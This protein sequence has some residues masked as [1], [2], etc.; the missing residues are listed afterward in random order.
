MKLKIKEETGKPVSQ[1]LLENRILQ[2]RKG[3]KDPVDGTVYLVPA[4]YG[5]IISARPGYNSKGEN[6]I[7]V[8]V[9]DALKNP[10][11]NKITS[12]PYRNTE[13]NLI[14]ADILN[15]FAKVT[16]GKLNLTA[17]SKLYPFVQFPDYGLADALKTLFDPL[18]FWVRADESGRIATGPRLGSPLSSA[19]GILGYPDQDTAPPAGS[20][21][22]VFPDSPGVE[23]ID[24]QWQ[25]FDGVYNQVRVLGQSVTAQQ[26]LGPN[27]LLFVEQDSSV[28]AKDINH[29][30]WPF[31]DQG[32]ASSANAVVAKNCFV[33]F[34]YST[35]HHLDDS[36]HTAYLSLM[37]WRG[38][39]D[40]D[41]TYAINEA[42]SYGGSSFACSQPSDGTHPPVDPLYWSEIPITGPFVSSVT[43]KNEDPRTVGVVTL[44][45]VTASYLIL[46]IEGKQYSV[47]NPYPR[48]YG[49]FDYNFKIWGQPVLS[50]SRTLTAYADYDP[51][52]VIGEA[53]DD[54]FDDN[55]T[56]Q[57]AHSPFGMGTP[58]EVFQDGVSLGKIAAD[59]SELSGEANYGVDFE[60]GRVVLNDTSYRTFA[61][62]QDGAG[63][64]VFSTGGTAHTTSRVFDL[65]QITVKTAQEV[66][67]TYRE[68]ASTFTLPGLQVGQ[69]YD[70]R[71]HFADPDNTLVKKRLF[72]VYAQ[73]AKVIEGLDIVAKTGAAYVAYQ[74]TI[75]GI[76]PD[77]SG[78]IVIK[79]TQRDPVSNDLLP[80]CSADGNGGGGSVGHEL[81]C[82]IE[83]VLPQGQGASPT[84]V[85]CGGPAINPTPTSIVANYAFSPVQETYGAQTMEIN[86]P[87]IATEAE[88]ALVAGYWV[89]YS[90]WKR[91][92]HAIKAASV[93]HLQPGDLVKWFNPR[94]GPSG[95]D[96]WG[97]VY[98][99][100]RGMAAGAADSDQYSC[101]VLYTQ[102]R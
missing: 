55:Q 87:L 34:N 7:T 39:W 52:I 69:G 64:H 86:D 89:N 97:Y 33:E 88:C 28:A 102:A 5:R 12:P 13:V 91:H 53:L 37:K 20:V 42:V 35:N 49:G 32:Q 24:A 1:T 101:Y 95:M 25:D 54:P 36:P 79:V 30:P 56:Y 26:T 41:T 10:V 21:A 66:Y 14:A 100:G 43:I 3:L 93:P 81:I 82:G 68:N 71:L 15:R 83:I 84:P 23:S 62:D 44:E 74:E 2:F 19:N 67:Q 59:G 78:V 47:G 77:V 50:H 65:S 4:F 17:I 22:Y 73:G 40:E 38:D 99:I 61:Q 46:K 16:S 94:L 48:K 45:S 18:L 31:S 57:A 6:V 90:A 70:I 85:N 80:E 11:R 27:R 51:S 98:E 72:S 58:V 63:E 92:P 8:T 60:K 9:G 76:G 75:T 29:K 96:F